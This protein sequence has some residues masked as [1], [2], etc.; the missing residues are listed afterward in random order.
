MFWNLGFGVFENFWGFS[1]LL[2]FCWNFGMVLKDLILKS[3]ALHHISII[4]VLSC[5]LDVCNWLCAEPMMQFLLHVTCSCISHAY[6]LFFSKYLLYLNCFGAF[7]IISFFPLSILF[8]LVVSMAPKRKSTPARNPL[9]SSSFSSSGSAP[10][11]L[12]FCD[13]D[14]HKAFSENFSRCGIHSE[15]PVILADFTDTDFPTVIHSWGWETLCDVSVT[16]PL[17]FVQEFYSNMHGIDRS[18]PLF[19][20]RVRGTCIPI[21]PQ[22][23]VDVLRVPRVEFP[24]YPSCE[25]LQTVSKDDLKLAFCEHPSKWGERQFI[26]CSAFAKGP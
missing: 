11:S 17:M 13:D 10:L 12:R 8:T 3:R 2:S 18:V 23:V 5:I 20:T 6:V 21:T 22:L 9:H 25:C 19:F 26:Y 24:D 1:K 4:T 15:R 16:C 7:L 14:A